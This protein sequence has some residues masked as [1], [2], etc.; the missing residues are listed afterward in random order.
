MARFVI[1][2]S[3]ICFVNCHLAAGQNAV[4]RR[5]ADIAGILEEK[6]VFTPTEHPFAYVGGG[7]GSMVLDHEFVIVSPAPSL[8][9]ELLSHPL[10]STNTQLNG[11]LNYRIDHRREALIAYIRM[12]DISSLLQLDHC[13]GR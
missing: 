12:G 1:G 3:S 8:L 9:M 6:A 5:N 7:D 4:R 11:D 10:N 13:S 2:D